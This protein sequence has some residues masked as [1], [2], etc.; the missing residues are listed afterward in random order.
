MIIMKE[1]P[2]VALMP[3]PGMGHIIPMVELAKKLIQQNNLKLTLIIPGS[4]LNPN[5]EKPFI[6]SLPNEINLVLLP[7]TN[8]DTSINTEPVLSIF[9]TVE[10]SLPSLRNLIKSLVATTNLVALI[11]DFF[12]TTAFDIADEFNISQYMF[13]ASNAM[14]LSLYLHLPELDST[15]P[16]KYQDLPRPVQLRGC[17]PLRG[18]DLPTS[19]QNRESGTYKCFVEQSKRYRMASGILVNTFSDIEG[20]TIK[21]LEKGKNVPTVYPVGPMVRQSTGQTEEMKT[22]KSFKWLDD[23]PEGS[24]LFVCFGSMGLLSKSQINELAFGLELSG[25]RFVWVIRGGGLDSLPEGF[26]ERTKDRGFLEFDWAP[27]AEILKH[28]STGGFVTHC[29]WN[30]VQ[31]SILSSVPMIA[32]PLYAEQRMNAALLSEHLKIAVRPGVRSAGG[33]VGRIEIANCVNNV[34][35]G[36]QGKKLRERTRALKVAGEKAV[37]V[38]GHSDKSLAEF[39]KILKLK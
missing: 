34:M 15:V 16:G 26:A 4:G 17:I 29:G 13:F 27:Q 21:A 35:E 8:S 23:Q 32:W 14:L 37:A 2:H 38:G 1:T 31:E 24:V 11:V 33:L 28:K 20:G 12:G 30:S 7:N 5:E 10:R 18:E 9:K 39:V 25:K 22:A 36:E 6:E 3:S 19:F